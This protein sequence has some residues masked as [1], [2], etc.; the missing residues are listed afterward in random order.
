MYVC[1]QVS[2]NLRMCVLAYVSA[3]GA[4]IGTYSAAVAAVAAGATGATASIL[5]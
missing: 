2:I 3:V 1:M 4:H 5:I